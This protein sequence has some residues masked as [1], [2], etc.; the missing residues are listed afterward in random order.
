[1][2]EKNKDKRKKIIESTENFLAL[3]ESKILSVISAISFVW[4]FVFCIFIV[5]ERIS[6]GRSVLFFNL[7]DAVSGRRELL[8]LAGLQWVMVVAIF[9]I[10][11]IGIDRLLSLIKKRIKK[12]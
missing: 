9:N 7:G 1:V 8:R 6:E 4:L 2:S 10:T 5:P 11:L 12:G 3:F